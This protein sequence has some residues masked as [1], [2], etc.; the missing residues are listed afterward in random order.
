[1]QQG[2][3][4]PAAHMLLGETHNA[5]VGN[6]QIYGKFL[7]EK[8]RK[9]RI[10]LHD[11]AHIGHQKFHQNALLESCGCRYVGLASKICPIA[12]IL[13][14]PQHAVDKTTSAYAVTINLDLAVDKAKQTRRL[15]ILSIYDFVAAV[16]H[17]TSRTFEFFSVGRREQ[18]AHRRERTLD[19]LFIIGFKDSHSRV[20]AGLYACIAQCHNAAASP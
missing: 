10:A 1:M 11:L 9:T 13:H 17:H 19:A 14:G 3:C 2:F 16:F 15:F 7:H 6:A 12:E 8:G 5:A 4:Q 20:K 18:L